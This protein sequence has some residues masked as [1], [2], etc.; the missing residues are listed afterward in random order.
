[1]DDTAIKVENVSKTF[2]LPH[3]KNSSIKS[4]AINFYKRKKGYELQRALNNVSFE[5]K[6]GEFFGIVGQNG[7]GKSTLLKLLAG[8]YTPTS[9]AITV[10]G[11]LTPFIELGVGFNPE[12]TG[13]GNVFLNGALLGFSRKQMEAMYD[14]IVQFAELERFMDQKLKNYSSGMQVRLA[15]SIAIRAQSDILV[16]DEVLAVGDEAFQQKCFSVFEKYK[17][18]KK[19]IVLVTHDMGT[20]E[21]FCDKALMLQ[22]GNVTKIGSPKTI[23]HLYS[24]INKASY[25]A[26]KTKQE[27]KKSLNENIKITVLDV[28]TKTPKKRF[29]H[30]EVALIRL[31]WEQSGV[32]NAGVTIMKQSGEYVFGTNTHGTKNILSPSDKEIYYTVKLGVGPGEYFLKA[33]LSGET[34]KDVLGFVE[35]GP[36]IIVEPPPKQ[37]VDWGGVAYLPH[38]WGAKDVEL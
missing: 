26:E 21:R 18:E 37:K 23:A 20:V 17:A 38:A 19:T 6:K 5:V 4:A 31:S 28:K 22:D 7:S 9:G 8:I 3:E 16:L 2:K 12:L 32:K 34:G 30:N 13:R 11:S 14:G 10:N 35:D 1:M 15:F 29:I 33:G 27:K 36:S 24:E 25:A